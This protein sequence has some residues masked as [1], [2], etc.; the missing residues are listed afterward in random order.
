MTTASATNRTATNRTATNE[1]A[2]GRRQIPLSA[3]RLM[4]RRLTLTVVFRRVV[5]GTP[6][7]GPCGGAGRRGTRRSRWFRSTPARGSPKPSRSTSTTCG[8]P[9]ARASC[10]STARGSESGRSHPP[11]AAQGP[12]RLARGAPRVAGSERRPRAVSQPARP[13]AER[14]GRP[15][16]DHGHRRS[17]RAR[18]PRDGSRAQ[19]LVRDRA[20][21]RRH[22]PRDRRRAARPRT[23]RNHTRLHA[24]D[25]RG[26]QQSRRSAARRPVE[27]GRGGLTEPESVSEHGYCG[28][29]AYLGRTPLSSIGVVVVGRTC[30]RGTGPMLQSG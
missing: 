22:R 30:V 1:N 18:R 5:V 26:P 13:P 21:A 6:T 14:Q 8:C 16:R 12:Y 15:R 3:Q 25:R 9:H 4:G 27:R 29:W 17:R 24:P 20:R 7:S 28:F 23:T 2:L 11:R 19:T 10:A